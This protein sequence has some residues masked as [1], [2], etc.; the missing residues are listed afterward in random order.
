MEML[1]KVFCAEMYRKDAGATVARSPGT[2]NRA[3]PYSSR[4]QIVHPVE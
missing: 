4:R 2:G 1:L 3:L